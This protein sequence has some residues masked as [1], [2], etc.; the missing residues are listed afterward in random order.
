MHFYSN[1]DDLYFQ[2]IFYNMLFFPEFVIYFV[3][4]LFFIIFR[5][6]QD[7]S[8]LFYK[9]VST[10]NHNNGSLIL[11]VIPC[12]ILRLEFTLK[13]KKVITASRATGNLVRVYGEA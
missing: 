4:L 3:Q 7:F 6:L 11:R 1:F 13:K 8:L 5:V 2:L 9:Q 12:G 10:D